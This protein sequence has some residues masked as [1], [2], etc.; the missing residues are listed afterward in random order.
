MKLFLIMKYVVSCISEKRN[1]VKK[2]KIHNIVPKSAF[3]SCFEESS[4]VLKG[5]FITKLSLLSISTKSDA[6]FCLL[7]ESFSG[8][9][10]FRYVTNIIK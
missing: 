8:D 7:Y 1:F 2:F 5:L 3:F 4:H 9:I 6:I 10:D